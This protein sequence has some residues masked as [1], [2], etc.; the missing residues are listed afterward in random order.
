[1][2]TGKWSIGAGI[3]LALATAAPA[4]ADEFPRTAL[5]SI[6]YREARLADFEGTAGY[7]QRRAA[8]NGLLSLS[9]DLNGDGHSDEVRILLNE[10][11]QIFYVAAAIETHQLDTYILE[12]G[13]LSEAADVGLRLAPAG[14]GGR[15]GITI[16]PI[17]GGEGRTLYFDG[18]E[19]RESPQTPGTIIS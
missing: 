4:G 16:I 6:G 13:T 10:E 19:F 7:A 15:P 18:Q 14:P 5:L 9:A 12:R 2:A 11:R 17:S 8:P 3:V 1:M